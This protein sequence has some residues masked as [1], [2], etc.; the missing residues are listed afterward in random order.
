MLKSYGVLNQT[1]FAKILKKVEKETRIPCL[2]SY[3]EKI[4]L[5]NFVSSKRLDELIAEV[6]KGYA[7]SFC[8]FLV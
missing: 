8:K 4:A 5:E 7:T 6:E 2:V 3:T 1:G